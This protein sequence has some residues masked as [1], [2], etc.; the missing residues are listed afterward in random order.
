M[1]R[2][3]AVLSTVQGMGSTCLLVLV[4]VLVVL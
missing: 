3:V 2:I 1:Y 4:P